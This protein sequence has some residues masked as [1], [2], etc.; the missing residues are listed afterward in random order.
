[1][2]HGVCAVQSP[3]LQLPDVG[4]DHESAKYRTCNGD[5]ENARAP[6]ISCSATGFTCA[7]A[8]WAHRPT[9]HGIQ[10]KVYISSATRPP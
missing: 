8:E 9:P 5:P 3:H 10:S 4:C 2:T 7:N 6:I 1:M